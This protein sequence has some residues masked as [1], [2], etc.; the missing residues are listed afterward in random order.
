MVYVELMDLKTFHAFVGHL[1]HIPEP[2]QQRQVQYEP[3]AEQSLHVLPI[4]AQAR[5]GGTPALALPVPGR[6]REG[7]PRRQREHRQRVDRRRPAP[8]QPHQQRARRQRCQGVADTGAQ[9]MDGKRVAA[10]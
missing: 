3:V 10:P 8:A 9:G 6:E 2:G 1:R 5:T 7:D 4:F